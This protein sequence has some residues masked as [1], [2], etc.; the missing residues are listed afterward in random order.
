LAKIGPEAAP[1][2]G[3]LARFIERGDDYARG[4][5]SSALEAIGPSALVAIDGLINSL[6][7]GP[8][9]ST[10][11]WSTAE[12]AENALVAIGHQGVDKLLSALKRSQNE[13]V[14]SRIPRVLYRCLMSQVESEILGSQLIARAVDNLEQALHREPSPRVKKEII[15]ILGLFGTY[16]QSAV[17]SIVKALSV[18]SLAPAAAK[19]LTE[20][21][22]PRYTIINALVK[23]LDNK[24][25]RPLAF[26]AL[27]RIRQPLR[28]V[29]PALLKI[30]NE[31]K[32]R[33]YDKVD[34]NDTEFEDASYY[35]VEEVLSFFNFVTRERDYWTTYQSRHYVFTPV[36]F[37]LLVKL[38]GTK[39]P[40]NL[41]VWA[42]RQ[43]VSAEGKYT[44]EV[45]R[46][47]SEGLY[48]DGPT[49]FHLAVAEA[50]TRSPLKEQQTI[51]SLVKTLIHPH[52]DVASQAAR[53]LGSMGAEAKNAIIDLIKIVSS[54]RSAVATTASE[55]IGTIAWALLDG[56]DFK[57]IPLLNKAAQAVK[58]AGENP[59]LIIQAVK[60]LEEL[61]HDR[62]AFKKAWAIIVSNP[63]PSSVVVLWIVQTVTWFLLLVVRPLALLS[64]NRLLRNYGDVK[65]PD[66]MGGVTIP[67]R[68]FLIV[69]F[70]N[71]HSRVLRAWVSVRLER[72]RENFIKR[73]ETVRS[74]QVHV[75]LPVVVDSSEVMKIGVKSTFDH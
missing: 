75:P 40:D 74:R 64:I 65:L 33:E 10:F 5:A 2:A 27:K 71:Y 36:S 11:R 58:S 45:E 32:L 25:T 20:I 30:V 16:A 70:L 61:R 44:I 14:R 4:R 38:I 24:A 9:D 41:R 54:K 73:Q 46:S 56:K 29:T 19:A 7:P 69:G 48:K 51:D 17:P 13:D 35:N 21:K 6:R 47:L 43:L 62:T 68:H 8:E 55:A 34:F 57:S 37:P 66:W 42:A 49:E 18:K 3:A 53:T 1:A 63:I 22:Q 12:Y 26:T 28:I 39:N 67:L 60:M 59:A 50:L 31:L 15:Q 23:A 72:S 52:P